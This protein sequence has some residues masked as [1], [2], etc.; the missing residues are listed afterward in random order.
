M[1]CWPVL[2]IASGV[3]LVLSYLYLFVMRCIG[4]GIVWLM[5]LLCEASLI[6]AGLYCWWL[7][8]NK[9]TPE[10]KNTY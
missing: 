8:A 2:L 5:I 1:I 7:R 3:A 9:Y 6:L 4:G 10:D